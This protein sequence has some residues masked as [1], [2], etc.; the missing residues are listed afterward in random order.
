M[1]RPFPLLV[2]AAA[3]L[4]AL[5]A[6]AADKDGAFVPKGVGLDSC[7]VVNEVAQKQ[8]NDLALLASWFDGYITAVNTMSQNLYDVAPWQEPRTIVSLVLQHCSQNPDDKIANVAPKLVEFLAPGRLETRSNVVDAKVGD[9]TVKIYAAVL[10]KAQEALI[11]EG[12]LSGAADGSFGP[13]TR[14][15]LEAFQ[16]K[17]SI[18]KTGLPDQETLFRLFAPR[19]PS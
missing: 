12:H 7:K 6:L 15:A 5:P 8:P 1:S 9:K 17:N 3:A 16:Q 11:K 2:A 18:T 4:A 10:K 14:A 13:K 19:R